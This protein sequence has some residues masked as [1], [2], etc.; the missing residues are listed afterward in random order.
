MT[1]TERKEYDA[2]LEQLRQESDPESL[3]ARRAEGRRMTADAAVAFA[4]AE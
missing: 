4:L 1:E 2:A 3:A